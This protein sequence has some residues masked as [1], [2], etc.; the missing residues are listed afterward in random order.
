MPWVQL[1][2]EMDTLDPA[3]V[4]AALLRHGAQ[5]ICL[6]DAGDDPVLEPAPGTTPLWPTT[7]M[8]AMF[9]ADVDRGSVLTA[10]RGELGV[11]ELPPWRFEFLEDRAWE[12]EWL[13]R[14]KPARFGRRLWICPTGS[15]PSGENS[16]VVEL[17]PGLAFGTGAHPTT[18]LCLEWLDEM[19]L[20]GR[21]VLD[22]GCGSG[23]LAIAAA[24][25]GAAHVTAL[26]IDHQALAATRANVSKNGMESSIDIL[27][28]ETE[29]QGHYDCV[30][31]NILAQPLLR[32]APQLAGLTAPGGHIVLSGILAEQA[33]EL[34]CRFG[35]WFTL[36]PPVHR[37]GWA[38]VSGRR[39][40]LT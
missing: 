18:A 22:F 8:T 32:L 30:L 11:D 38:R 14:F 27:S 5:A 3:T 37:E 4:E 36:D 26:D 10:I 20:D 7:R 31:A 6:Q 34:T 17:D 33:A 21:R 28:L 23:I 15:V 9:Q 12:R 13:E 40:I 24:K 29:P 19:T 39:N 2:M 1:I 25:L 16:V 35:D